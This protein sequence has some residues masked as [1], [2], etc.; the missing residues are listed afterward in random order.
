MRGVSI[1]NIGNYLVV[2]TDFGVIVK[3]DGDDHLEITLPQSYFS[4]VRF[5]L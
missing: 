2:E 3:Y 5:N 1:A 4:K